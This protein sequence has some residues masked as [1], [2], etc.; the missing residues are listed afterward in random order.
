VL[1]KPTGII[2]ITEIDNFKFTYGFN[3]IGIQSV[4]IFGEKKFYLL[5]YKIFHCN[6]GTSQLVRRKNSENK[7]PL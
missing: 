7:I 4:R 2:I 5:C 3:I 1:T 6:K